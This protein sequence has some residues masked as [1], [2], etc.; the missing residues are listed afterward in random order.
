[1]CHSELFSFGLD[2]V[3]SDVTYNILMLEKI[4]AAKHSTAQDISF[5]AIDALYIHVSTNTMM[6]LALMWLPL[7]LI[8]ENVRSCDHAALNGQIAIV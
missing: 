2:F 5:L 7:W 6:Q 3:V 8:V 1:M 4:Y